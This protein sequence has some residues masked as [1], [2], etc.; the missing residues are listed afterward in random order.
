M[1]MVNESLARV[2]SK[3][4]KIGCM[5]FCNSFGVLIKNIYT[6]LS[7]MI[8][9]NIQKIRKNIIMKTQEFLQILEFSK[10]PIF[11]FSDFVRIL[12]K[13]E[14]YV[15]VFVNRL[16]KK[17]LVRIEKNKYALK[18]T[19]PLLVASNLLFPS[20]ISFISAYGYYDLTTQLPRTVYVVAL[21]QKKILHY[22]SNLIQFVKFKDF[23]FFG[24]SRELLENKFLFVA[25]PEKA[26]LDSLY[27][28][29]YC[30]VPETFF[31]LKNAKLN[32]EKL[33]TFAQQM[34]SSALIARLGYLLELVGIDISE[35]LRPVSKNYTVL[36]PASPKK[37]Q[38]EK[39]W[40]LIINEVLN[41]VE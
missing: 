20:Y 29:K 38:K 24:F 37:G 25:E 22:N 19:N 23:R 15:K 33:I 30:P 16:A 7:K 9:L 39:K 21:K 40:R 2:L 35:R 18:R 6:K 36:N 11:S 4:P 27:L 8:T 10:K 17:Q 41:N 3:L 5:E 1:G 34:K 28:P 31:A 26:I 14:N 12:G 32:I 13:S